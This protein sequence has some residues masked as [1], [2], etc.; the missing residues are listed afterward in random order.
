MTYWNSERDDARENVMT[1]TPSLP[2]DRATP[3]VPR[4]TQH[5]G[6]LKGTE[7]S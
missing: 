7:R 2:A 6:I 1:S 4:M 5:I 3:I